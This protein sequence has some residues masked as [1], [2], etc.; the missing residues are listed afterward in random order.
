MFEIQDVAQSV[1]SIDRLFR[2]FGDP[3]R[4]RIMNVLAAGDL[5]VRDIVNVLGLPQP[6][7][8]RHLA[9]LRRAGL[10]DVSRE[11]R[12]AHYR[13][14]EPQNDVHNN[15][16]SCVRSCFVGIPSLDRERAAASLLTEGAPMYETASA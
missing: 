4:L 16:L 11:W 15:L 7:V 6:A 9:Y 14:S 5:C 12:F 13:L 3:V 1:P 8:S 2:G 10:V